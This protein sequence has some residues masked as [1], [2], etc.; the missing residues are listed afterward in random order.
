MKPVSI[1]M[2]GNGTAILGEEPTNVTLKL[3]TEA[4]VEAIM[5]WG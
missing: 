2:A 1:W 3:Q 5:K 4:Q